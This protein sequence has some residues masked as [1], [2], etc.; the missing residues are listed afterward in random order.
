MV[1]PGRWDTEAGPDE[2]QRLAV[3]RLEWRNRLDNF[4]AALGHG[5]LA[6]HKERDVTAEFGGEFVQRRLAKRLVVEFVERE[7]GCR[8]VAAAATE[9]ALGGDG[10]FEVDADA[11]CDSSLGRE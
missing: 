5:R 3:E 1:R 4:A 7:E 11:A 6:L 9:T 2:Q 8:R 10:F